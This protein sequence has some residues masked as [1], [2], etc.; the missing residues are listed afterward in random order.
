MSTGPQA[1]RLVELAA[2]NIKISGG[3]VKMDNRLGSRGA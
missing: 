3:G 2:M 1:W